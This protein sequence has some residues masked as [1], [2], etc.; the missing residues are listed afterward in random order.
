M[1]RLPPL[2]AL[3]LFFA[4][5]PAAAR[6]A[7]TPSEWHDKSTLQFWTIDAN[8]NENWTTVWM[9]IIEGDVYLRLGTSAA[10]R[11]RS[12]TQWP[13]I[14]VRMGGLEFP[15]VRADQVPQMSGE[16]A[17]AMAEKYWSDLLVR[18]LPHPM[19]LRLRSASP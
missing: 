14:K 16:V 5:A 6:A 12:N 7:W 2:L 15:H 4:F 9:V 18:Y 17:D 13:Y 1:K 8:Q 11:M 10:D 19:T 3:I